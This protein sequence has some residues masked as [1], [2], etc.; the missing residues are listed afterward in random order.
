MHMNTPTSQDKSM[1]EILASIRQTITEDL[2]TM[3]NAQNTSQD[4]DSKPFSSDDV[5]ELTQIIQ[6]D[7]TIIDLREEQTMNSLS[8]EDNTGTLA[9]DEPIASQADTMVAENISAS[10]RDMPEENVETGRA[11][12]AISSMENMSEEVVAADAPFNTT[13]D[14][15]SQADI[16][17]SLNQS[18]QTGEALSS[19]MASP[20]PSEV[21][22]P[23]ASS[24]FGEPI[25]DTAT[26]RESLAAL[27]GLSRFS[28]N[29]TD[30]GNNSSAGAQTIDGLVRELLRPMLKEWLDANLPSL[31]K[32]VV[33]E[34]VERIFKERN[35]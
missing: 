21:A 6:E 10:V 7:G 24:G 29:A 31:V 22:P 26:I 20:S 19:N 16:A 11:E 15:S 3:S 13:S 14:I 23:S 28:P 2:G 30:D 9:M 1:D 32:W 4:T 27:S 12:S 18:E 35:K 5:L 17:A 25:M 8:L 33:T 34:Q